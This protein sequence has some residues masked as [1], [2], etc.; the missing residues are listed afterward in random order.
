MRI[1]RVFTPLFDFL[2]RGNSS[3]KEELAET[4]FDYQLDLVTP[5]IMPLV[6]SSRKVIRE[7]LKRRR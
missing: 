7:S 1:K 6:A 3:D 4:F 2:K 5:G